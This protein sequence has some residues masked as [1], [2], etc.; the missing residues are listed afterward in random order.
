MKK[1]GLSYDKAAHLSDVRR[2]DCASIPNIHVLLVT[3]N[4][5][6]C[7]CCSNKKRMTFFLRF[8]RGMLIYFVY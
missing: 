6:E 4:V 5:I 2:A 8:I 3:R 7:G 1:E